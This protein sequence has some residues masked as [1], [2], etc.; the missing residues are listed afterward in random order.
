MKRV[1]V[2]GMQLGGARGARF[3]SNPCIEIR[4]TARGIY[5]LMLDLKAKNVA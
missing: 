3:E 1:P 4:Y 5:R 2:R